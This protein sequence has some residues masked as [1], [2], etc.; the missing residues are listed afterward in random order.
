ML[1]SPYDTIE[2]EDIAREDRP[3]IASTENYGST[4][5]TNRSADF[6]SSATSTPNGDITAPY[7]AMKSKERDPI[8]SGTGPNG[9]RRPPRFYLNK[10][11]VPIYI[12]LCVVICILC[13]LCV[14]VV[15]VTTV[16][17]SF[18][19]SLFQFLCTNRSDCDP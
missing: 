8:D 7:S 9:R 19:P 12:Q 17:S 1:N 13:G 18:P 4:S 5:T 16:S 14:M 2:K 11:R 10:F 15:A 6:P 3:T